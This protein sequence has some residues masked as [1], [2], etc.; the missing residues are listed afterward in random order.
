[1]NRNRTFALNLEKLE[2]RQMMAGDVNAFA[3][4]RILYLQGDVLSNGVAVVDA[5]G[6]NI[7]VVG[8][9]QA[10]SATTINDGV[11]QTFTKIKDFVITMGKGDDAVVVSNIFVKGSLF[12]Q[13]SLGND[14]VGLGA[15]EDTGLVDDAVDSLLG[16]LTVKNSATIT[17]DAG[18]DTI[19]AQNVTINGSLVLSTG[20]GNDTVRLE[21]H[22]DPGDLDFV[23]GVTVVKSATISTSTGNDT[24]YLERLSAKSLTVALSNEDDSIAV[25]D[26]TITK[27]ASFNGENGIDTYTDLGGNTFGKLKRKNFEVIV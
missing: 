11:S 26:V 5:G 4:S 23:S 6:G 22:G 3:I 14:V 10:G 16:A 25:E 27:T 18:D 19:I 13:G 8:L 20:I 9:N 15:F 17:T 7:N 2:A 21:S 12:I 1:M 24:V